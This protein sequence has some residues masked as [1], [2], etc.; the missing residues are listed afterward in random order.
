MK[1]EKSW[2][3]RA[4]AALDDQFLERLRPEERARERLRWEDWE[5][6][7]REAV[8]FAEN[9]IRRRKWRGEYQGVVPGGLDGED[10]ANQVMAEVLSGKGRIAQGLVKSRLLLELKRL[11]SGRVRVLHGRKE[12]SLVRSEWEVSPVK[13][14]EEPISVFEGVCGTELDAGEA[15]TQRERSMAN[16]HAARAMEMKLGSDDALRRIFQCLR[17]GILTSEE[18]AERLGMDKAS[19]A[20]GRRRLARRL[21]RFAGRVGR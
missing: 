5:S 16:Q 8:S 6:V 18:I 21:R 2:P 9:E 12:T 13:D 14:G 11:I 4:Q 19:V 10:V 15:V 17:A 20:R 7:R 3:A 1:P